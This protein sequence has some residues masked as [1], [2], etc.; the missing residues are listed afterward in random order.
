MNRYS[1]AALDLLDHLLQL[2][3]NKRYNAA[4]ALDH[5]YFWTENPRA[6]PQAE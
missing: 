1:V 6:M 4:Q 3:P 5:A 2:D